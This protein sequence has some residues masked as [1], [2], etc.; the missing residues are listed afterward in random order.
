MPR[1]KVVDLCPVTVTS[2]RF[3]V[4]KVLIAVM[5]RHRTAAGDRELEESLTSTP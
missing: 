5:I 3:T 1:V 2:I 4:R